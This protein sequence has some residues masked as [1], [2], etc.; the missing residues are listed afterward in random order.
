MSDKALGEQPNIHETAVVRD[1]S[2]GAWTEVGRDTTLIE[3]VLGDY[4]Y[5]M[6][7]CHL[8]HV[9]VGKFA[10]IANHARLGPSNHP[11]WRATQHHFTYRSSMFGFGEDDEAFFAW[12]KAA[13]VSVGHDVW[14]GHGAVVLPGV[15]VGI[16][17]VVGAGAVVTKDVPDYA[18]VGGVPAKII[19]CRFPEDVAQ[20]LLALAWWDW[21]HEK[22]GLALDD[23]RNLSVQAFVQ[24]YRQEAEKV[25]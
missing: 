22:L 6:D 18:I 16:G 21:P 13:P 8:M 9:S 4:S 15:S 12:R 25:S 19:R 3:A 17:A 20:G 7:R 2:L 10:S 1:S 11:M 23:F 14:I 24:K 5:V